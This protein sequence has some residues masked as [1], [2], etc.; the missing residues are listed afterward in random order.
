MHFEELGSER[1][2]VNYREQHVDVQVSKY[3]APG[4]RPFFGRSPG[5]TRNQQEKKP[6]SFERDLC[7]S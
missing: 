5:S 4:S 3:G 1:T 2:R 6:R 7:F